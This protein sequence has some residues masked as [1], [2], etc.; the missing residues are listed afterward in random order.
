[1]EKENGL[2]NC[3][4]CRMEPSQP[5]NFVSG[6]EFTFCLIRQKCTSVSCTPTYRVR[7]QSNFKTKSDIRGCH[8]VVS[9]D[10][11]LPEAQQQ[12][13]E[14]AKEAAQCDNWKP[15]RGKGA[16]LAFRNEEKNTNKGEVSCVCSTRFPRFAVINGTNG[17]SAGTGS[18]R[19]DS[20]AGTKVPSVDRNTWPR[21]NLYKCRCS[22]LAAWCV[23]PTIHLVV[24]SLSCMVPTIC[25]QGVSSANSLTA[26]T[27]LFI[28][29]PLYLSERGMKHCR[30][31]GPSLS[32]TKTL[33]MHPE[34]SR[35]CPRKLVQ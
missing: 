11:R 12:A 32:T 20:A 8:I 16:M 19:G 33:G 5:S 21:L 23:S 28:P 22:K 7:A 15:S 6:D 3:L 1:M 14:V 26:F 34:W 30:R 9:R 25:L 31:L 17:H 35:S 18:Q 24:Q 27:L 2:K 13:E 29:S 4:T 10:R